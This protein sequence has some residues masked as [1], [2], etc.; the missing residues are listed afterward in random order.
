MNSAMRTIIAAIVL[1]ISSA[2]CLTLEEGLKDPAKYILYDAS[3]F[4]VGMHAGFAILLTYS[5]LTS[6]I[7]IVH[8]IV[9]CLV[10]SG[11]VA[12]HRK[13]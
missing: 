7:A 11:K 8:G 13:R 5:I 3:D 9:A 1:L 12:P 2:K 10:H 6:L 4:N